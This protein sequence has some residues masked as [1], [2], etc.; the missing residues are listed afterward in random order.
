MDQKMMK[1]LGGVIAAFV[2]LI[3]VLFLISSCTNTKYTYEKLEEKMLNIAKTYYEINEKELP[4]QDKDTRSYTLKKMISD[5]KIDE[6]SELFNDESIKCDGNVTVTNNNGFYIYTPSLTCGND[7][8]TKYLKDAI[9]ENSL[10][11]DAAGAGLYEAGDEYIF[12]GDV[13]DNYVSFAGKTFRIIRINEDGTIRLIDNNGLSEVVWDSKYNSDIQDTN[14][15]N[16]YVV[17]ENLYSNIKTVCDNYY[18][19]QNVWTDV[20]RSYITTQSVCIGKRSK[21]DVTHDGST[22]C[23]LKL[24]NQLFSPLAVYEFLQAG[25]DKNCTNTTNNA[26]VNYNWFTSMPNTFWTATADVD[27]TDKVY[28]IYNKPSVSITNSYSHLSVV[29]NLTANTVYVSGNG[30]KEDPYTFK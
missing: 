23:S 22:E 18:N 8:K 13:K 3:F 4:Q 16:E 30:T 17:S 19:N 26:C 28:T 29:F 2:I 24:D 9:I 7:Y 25:L 10:N 12:K 15:I 20:D 5:G 21:L 14:G 1:T 11:E 27:S 6:V